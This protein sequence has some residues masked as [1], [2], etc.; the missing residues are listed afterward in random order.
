MLSWARDL[1]L[2]SLNHTGN[3][4]PK[5]RPLPAGGQCSGSLT[6]QPLLC[7]DGGAQREAEFGC[8]S[9]GA[10]GASLLRAA[11]R[12]SE[13]PGRKGR[14]TLS[15]AREADLFLLRLPSSHRRVSF[16]QNP[17]GKVRSERRFCRG[18]KRGEKAKYGK[19]KRGF[20][21]FG[22][23]AK[24]LI[25]EPEHQL[26]NLRDFLLAYNR[27]SEICFNRCASNMNYRLLTME[28]EKCLDNCAGKLIHSNHRLMGAYVQLMP[29]I[30][31]RR[32]TDYE[33]KAAVAE[34][35]LSPELP[36]AAPELP[37]VSTGTQEAVSGKGTVQVEGAQDALGS[38]PH[39]DSG[40]LESGKTQ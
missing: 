37:L 28:E 21:L 11:A 7:E 25:M 35:D 33:S 14:E 3:Y 13:D 36:P 16:P 12:E 4:V 5:Y 18:R 23:C 32:I 9:S 40:K 17:V 15:S 6:S 31:Q 29:A 30:V 26:R 27:M 38:I 22:V 34:K 20:I 19:K 2:L 10:T 39:T 8:G 24:L 1:Q